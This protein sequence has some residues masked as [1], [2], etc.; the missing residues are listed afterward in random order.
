[1]LRPQVPPRQVGTVQ[2]SKRLHRLSW[3][4]PMLKQTLMHWRQVHWHPLKPTQAEPKPGIAP[5]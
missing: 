2:R 1:M 3:L 5:R 4:H